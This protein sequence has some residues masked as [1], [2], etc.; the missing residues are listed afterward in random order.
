MGW[1]TETYRKKE[2][3]VIRKVLEEWRKSAGSSKNGKSF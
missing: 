1:E 3:D 2:L